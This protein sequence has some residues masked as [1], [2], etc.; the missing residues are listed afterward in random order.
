MK[1]ECRPTILVADDDVVMRALL[2]HH[3]QQAGYT[4]LCTINGAEAVEQTQAQAVDLVI[5]DL[6]MPFLN[7]LEVCQQI[8]GDAQTVSVPVI[9]LSAPA[10]RLSRR[11]VA[12]T[13]LYAWITKPFNP[14]DLIATVRKALGAA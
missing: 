4:V 9:M 6:Y 14:S 11:E 12:E 8:H 2:Q 5:T 7:G 13:G 10:E 1:S 3:L